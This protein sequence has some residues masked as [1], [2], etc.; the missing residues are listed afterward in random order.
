MKLIAIFLLL[1]SFGVGHAAEK[2][3]EFFGFKEA[4]EKKE[5]PAPDTIKEIKDLIQTIENK[6][7]RDQLVKAL[8]ALTVV[9]KAKEP[10]E[11]LLLTSTKVI[12]EKVEEIAEL[13]LTAFTAIINFPHE[14]TAGIARLSATEVA[15][16]LFFDFL[17][18]LIL[19][20]GLSILFEISLFTYLRRYCKPTL[21]FAGRIL[22]GLSPLCVFSFLTSLLISVLTSPPLKESLI[23]LMLAILSTRL[24]WLASSLIFSPRHEENRLVPLSDKSAARLHSWLLTI[25]QMVILGIITTQLGEHLLLSP[26]GLQTW[27]R[28]YGFLITLVIIGFVNAH[29]ESISRWLHPETKNIDGSSRLVVGLLSVLSRTWYFLAISLLLGTYLSWALQAFDYL[30]YLSQGSLMTVILL[31]ATIAFSRYLQGYSQ[32]WFRSNKNKK[33]HNPRGLWNNAFQALHSIIPFIQA[34]IYL[35]CLISV[36]WVWGFDFLQL[37]NDDAMREKIMQGVS[38]F[39]ILW[40]TRI[41]WITL[42]LIID[43]HM[44]P[45]ALKGRT[46]EPS[47]VA[48]TLGPIIRT[49]SHFILVII[50][51]VIIAQQ[52]IINIMPFVYGVGAIAFAFSL[53]APGLAKDLINGILI[54]IEG[55]LAVGEEVIIGPHTG[56]IESITPRSIFLRH[57]NGYVQSIPFSEVTNIINKSRDFTVARI[58]LPIDFMIPV[59]TVYKSLETTAER[60]KSHPTFGKMMRTSLTIHGV[61]E[62]LDKGYTVAASIRIS[63]DPNGHFV[64]E[65][66]RQ[67]KEIA[68]AE[69]ILIANYRHQLDILPKTD[70]R[71]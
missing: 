55:N 25:G 21:S 58:N 20:F 52:L 60:I 10:Q 3:A 7:K 29:S 45:I 15:P 59:S 69:N 51:F 64:L 38:I 68:E 65:F 44:K 9:T 54:L 1:F 43:Y 41:L 66:Y 34:I 6:S 17:L 37:I 46:I 18:R 19:V 16:R 61:T 26:L 33:T 32:G 28:F 11:S 47:M 31:G 56:V 8:K 71:L 27:T 63:P 39:I 24:V 53:G 40:I 35:L 22:W 49:I 36:S 50:S 48:K 30:I 67:W 62:N 23:S 12:A 4:S 13:A 57:G 42:D 70:M 2:G 14:V 5:S